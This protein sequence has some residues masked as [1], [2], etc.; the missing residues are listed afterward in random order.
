MNCTQEVKVALFARSPVIGQVKQRL[1]QEIGAVAAFN[2]YRVLLQTALD[3]TSQFSTTIWYEGSVEVWGQIVLEK[4]LRKQPAGGLGFRMLTSLH[5]GATVVI[6][7]DIPLMSAA[8][9]E[10]ASDRLRTGHD[11]VLGPTEDGGY[12]LIGMNE[13]NEF[14]FESILWGTDCVLEQTLSRAQQLGLQVALLPTLWDV[15]NVNDYERWL[16]KMPQDQT[17]GC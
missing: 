7:A 15:D 4:Q 13:P 5:E 3:A 6:G 2:C 17:L 14:M 9:I 16:R 11:V 1:A 8:Y 10:C 12:C